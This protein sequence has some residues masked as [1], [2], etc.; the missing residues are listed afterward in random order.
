MPGKFRML[1][2]SELQFW[3]KQ[4]QSQ[5]QGKFLWAQQTKVIRNSLVHIISQALNSIQIIKAFI[6]CICGFAALYVC[7]LYACSILWCQKRVLDIPGS[8]V[9][10]GCETP[11]YV[12]GT[13]PM[14]SGRSASAFNCSCISPAPQMTFL[15]QTKV[16]EIL[17]FV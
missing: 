5:E 4:T 7:G 15:R 3:G 11:M 1:P 8:G 2:K 17:P 12:L 6:S 10:N 14:P 9:T 13:E 16:W